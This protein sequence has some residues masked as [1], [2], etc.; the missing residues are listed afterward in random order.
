MFRGN[1]LATIDDKGRL[2][3]PSRYCSVIPES[4]G[5][6]FFV[7]SV[8]GDCAHLYPL[9]AWKVIEAK[10]A[11]APSTHP[12]SV[13]YRL[14][15]N[16]YGQEPEMDRADRVLIPALLRQEAAIAG[17][18]FVIGDNDHLKIWNRSRFDA[19]VRKDKLTAADL[20]AL[21]GFHI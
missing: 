6:R 5:R 19:A 17:E 1:A 21:S 11:N 13:K 14:T 3:V 4:Y 8:H 18:V 15:V 20:D 12:S 2:K 7:T 16:Y 9:E 10:L